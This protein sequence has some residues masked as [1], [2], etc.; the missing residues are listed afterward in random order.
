MQ[1]NIE[2]VE[3]WDDI[4]WWLQFIAI[5]FRENIKNTNFIRIDTTNRTDYAYNQALNIMA[6][7]NF[8]SVQSQYIQK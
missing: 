2:N 7:R 4:L 1:T 5:M 6:C 8:N 3:R